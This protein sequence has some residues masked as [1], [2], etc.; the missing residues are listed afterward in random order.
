MFLSSLESRVL[1]FVS[2]NNNWMPE[3]VLWKMYHRPGS[4]AAA[5]LMRQ[6]LLA[7]DHSLGV[8]YVPSND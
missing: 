3:L 7:Y 1:G 4:Q 8:Y 5:S 6:G 2:N